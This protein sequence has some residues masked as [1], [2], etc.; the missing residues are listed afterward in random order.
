MIQ[1]YCFPLPK[2]SDAEKDRLMERLEAQIYDFCLDS[3]SKS[4]DSTELDT[5]RHIVLQNFLERNYYDIDKTIEFYEVYVK[6][7]KEMVSFKLE[8]DELAGDGYQ[9]TDTF[10]KWVGTDR[11]GRPC[12][13]VAGGQFHPRIHRRHAGQFQKFMVETFEHGCMLA[14]GCNSKQIG[15]VYDRRNMHW[16]NID[17]HLYQKTHK[18]WYNLRNYYSQWVGA[19][20]IVHVSW[21]A[22]ILYMYIARPILK[23]L[24]VSQDIVVLREAKDILEY[25]DEENLPQ[26]FLGDIKG[27]KESTNYIDAE[28]GKEALKQKVTPPPSPMNRVC[29]TLRSRQITPPVSPGESLRHY[30]EGDEE[31]CL[32]GRAGDD[33]KGTINDSSSWFSAPEGSKGD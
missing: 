26:G 27:E 15:I 13:F 25:I 30:M 19:L 23:W 4:T 9:P 8:D 24:Q 12:C 2:L 7:R 33:G 29:T 32:L 10:A 21:F 6:W 14:K 22:W 18:C 5:D 31:E 3:S 1:R 16:D 11:K 28:S 20:Y 17:V